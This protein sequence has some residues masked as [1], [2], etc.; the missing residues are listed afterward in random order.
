MLITIKAPFIREA[1]CVAAA[2]WNLPDW[3]EGC[4]REVAEGERMGVWSGVGCGGL[5]SEGVND[6][7]DD[8]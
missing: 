7:D 5:V 2:C 4:D 1:L 3:L 8:V 6:D